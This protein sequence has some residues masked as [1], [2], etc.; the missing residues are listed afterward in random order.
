MK[1][2]Q[3]LKITDIR[4]PDCPF[5]DRLEDDDFH[6]NA[7]GINA[8]GYDLIGEDSDDFALRLAEV[9]GVDFDDITISN[10][11]NADL[12]QY[13]PTIPSSSGK[14]FTE[15]IP[16]YVAVS[17]KDVVSAKE[18]RVATDIHARLGVPQKAKVIVLG[19]AKDA[20]LELAWPAADRHR[21]I[22]E[23]AKLDIHAIVPPDYSVWA[24]QTHAERLINQK[25]SIIMYKELI[26]AGLPAIP[27]I[28]W[29]ARKD[30]DEHLQF[31]RRH[32]AIRTVAMDLQTLGTETEWRQ[33]IADLGY[34]AANVGSDMRCLVTGPSVPPRI[35]QVIR[36]LPNVTIT[37]SA[38]AQKAVRRL[39]L[40]EDLTSSLILGVD[41]TDIMRTNDVMIMDAIDRAAEGRLEISTSTDFGSMRLSKTFL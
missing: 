11:V 30:L 6:C 28:T 14:L 41:K 7:A 32:P 5:G 18:L 24:N 31:L 29:Y 25:K 23:I 37:N 1:H 15:Y 10:P 27:H 2:H 8:R 9:N 35:E 20:L 38:A 17:L 22:S 36:I 33:L 34:F 12:P 21:I 40:A 39:L 19:F 4:R 3:Q 26:E 16:E 13:M